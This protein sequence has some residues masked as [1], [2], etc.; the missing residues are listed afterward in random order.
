M[1][2]Y[3]HPATVVLGGRTLT[4]DYTD[5]HALTTFHAVCDLV[6]PG[7][8]RGTVVHDLTEDHFTLLSMSLCPLGEERTALATAFRQDQE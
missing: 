2:A 4:C 1:T 5:A 8:S 7:G 3:K 6:G